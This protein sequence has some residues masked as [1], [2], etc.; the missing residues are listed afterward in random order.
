MKFVAVQGSEPGSNLLFRLKSH[1][2]HVQTQSNSPGSA[3]GGPWSAPDRPAL[4]PE[5]QSSEAAVIFLTLLVCGQ[6][7]LVSI[8][9]L[10]VLLFQHQSNECRVKTAQ[11]LT[12]IQG[13]ERGILRMAVALLCMV[14]CLRDQK[15]LAMLCKKLFVIRPLNEISAA[16]VDRRGLVRLFPL[17]ICIHPGSFGIDRSCNERHW[18]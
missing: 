8:T 2:V 10:F 9:F 17:S 16:G 1:K 14:I 11:K 6:T 7:A 18:L 12:V 15:K 13:A 4:M 5:A 3:D